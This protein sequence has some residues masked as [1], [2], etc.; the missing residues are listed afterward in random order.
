MQAIIA[1]DGL[2]RQKQLIQNIERVVFQTNTVNL[3]T[4]SGKKAFYIFGEGR[5]KAIEILDD[6]VDVLAR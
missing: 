3:Y 6:N 5:A 2:P 4:R 1:L